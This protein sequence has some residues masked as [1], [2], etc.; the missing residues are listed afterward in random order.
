MKI[1]I[2]GP[3]P[4]RKLLLDAIRQQ[5][6]DC[7]IEVIDD[8]SDISRATEVVNRIQ[9]IPKIVIHDAP[10]GVLPILSSEELLMQ[11][12]DKLLAIPEDYKLS[13][14]DK[15]GKKGK[16]IRNWEKKKFWEKV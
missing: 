9:P 2:I 13:L 7:F 16:F 3:I 15:R 12:I 4:D 5:I 10:I 1:G 6:P 8:T 11:D 14:P